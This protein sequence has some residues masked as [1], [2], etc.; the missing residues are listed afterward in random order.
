M[1]LDTTNIKAQTDCIME[2]HGREIQEAARRV[3]AAYSE[4]GARL[5]HLLLPILHRWGFGIQRGGALM[6]HLPPDTDMDVVD[7]TSEHPFAVVMD[8][9]CDYHLWAFAE[10]IANALWEKAYVVVGTPLNYMD[11][12]Y[13][14]DE[15]VEY[16]S[17]YIEDIPL[18]PLEGR[19]YLWIQI[20]EEGDLP[21]LFPCVPIDYEVP[22]EDGGGP[23]YLP[24]AV[25]YGPI[26]REYVDDIGGRDDY[27]DLV[28]ALPR[29]VVD[30]NGKF[31]RE[32]Q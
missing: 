11:D 13:G 15:G 31:R 20:E 9:E 28:R 27:R 23:L 22:A 18:P 25:V 32:Q 24:G 6:Y 21:Y 26:T 14:D 16:L 5:R 4:V 17:D 3:M 29:Y 8:K 10:P 1:I 12:H 7:L 2:W 19:E 30:D